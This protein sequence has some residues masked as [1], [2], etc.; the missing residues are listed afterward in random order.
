MI[1][2]EIAFAQT[3]TSAYDSAID[4]SQILGFTAFWNIDGV[5]EC[6]APE[7]SDRWMHAVSNDAFAFAAEKGI[8]L[9]QDMAHIILMPGNRAYHGG[10]I[11]TQD[12]ATTL[13][14]LIG[15][16]MAERLEGLLDAFNAGEREDDAAIARGESPSYAMD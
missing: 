10:R 6:V 16:W 15:M 11:F 7:A 12:Q 8:T 5:R 9:T 2:L 13:S 1:Q 14:R 4:F 3:A